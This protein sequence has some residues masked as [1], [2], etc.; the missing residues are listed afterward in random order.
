MF[1]YIGRDEEGGPWAPTIFEVFDN[2]IKYDLFSDNHVFAAEF[3]AIAC[4]YSFDI[5]RTLDE[6]Q[7][8]DKETETAIQGPATRGQI[9]RI[10]QVL[11]RA[12]AHAVRTWTKEEVVSGALTDKTAVLLQN[13]FVSDEAF[14][15]TFVQEFLPPA[16]RDWPENPSGSFIP[17]VYASVVTNFKTAT[18]EDIKEVLNIAETYLLKE[19][20][21]VTV[22]SIFDAQDAS[23]VFHECDDD[24]KR[25]KE[26]SLGLLKSVE[27]YICGGTPLYQSIEKILEMFQ[28]SSFFFVLPGGEPTNK[29]T[30]KGYMVKRKQE[31]ATSCADELEVVCERNQSKGKLINVK[32]YIS[33]RASAKISPVGAFPLGSVCFP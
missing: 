2:H 3:G 17:D 32:W 15:K 27:P 19:K 7:Y 18:E 22:N 26:K 16:C 21:G 29:E 12:G 24:E 13:K 25:S 28:A 30:E 31:G 8:E 6:I 11:E 14:L 20:I 5:M 1:H 10:L 4:E 23:N 33:S 9:D